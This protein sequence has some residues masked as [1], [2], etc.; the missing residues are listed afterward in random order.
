MH[1]RS[2]GAAGRHA[3]DEARV[4]TDQPLRP[5]RFVPGIHNNRTGVQRI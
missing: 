2:G 1:T 5:R 4:L 3:I